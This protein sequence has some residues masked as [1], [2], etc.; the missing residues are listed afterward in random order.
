MDYIDIGFVAFVAAQ[1]EIAFTGGYFQKARH[2]GITLP[3]D[4]A[5]ALVLDQLAADQ[6]Q[7]RALYDQYRQ[8]DRRYAAYDFNPLLV[9][10]IIRPW[11]KREGASLDD[12]RLIAP[13]PNLIIAKLSEA[14]IRGQV[15][16]S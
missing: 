5:I 14:I 4:E 10:P 6:W 2:Q 13:L 9:H 15:M 16:Y 7:M 12:D 3:D 8:R 1:A 11:K